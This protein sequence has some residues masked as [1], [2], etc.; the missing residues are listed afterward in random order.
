M[1]G[2]YGSPAPGAPGV[3]AR[4]VLAPAGAKG[5]SR[6]IAAAVAAI[7]KTREVILAM[8]TLPSFKTHAHLSRRGKH[9]R[10]NARLQDLM[11]CGASRTYQFTGRPRSYNHTWNSL[12][13]SMPET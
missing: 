7:E 11:R 6:P 8:Q 13:R 10:L 2:K 9:A 12:R 3:K 4:W 5:A 1:S